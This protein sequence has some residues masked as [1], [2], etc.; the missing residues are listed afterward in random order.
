MPSQITVPFIGCSIYSAF[1][2]T[3][4]VLFVIF[5]CLAFRNR[6]KLQ[7]LVSFRAHVKTRKSCC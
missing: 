3:V 1:F 6:E 2:S 5:F 7:L 4:D